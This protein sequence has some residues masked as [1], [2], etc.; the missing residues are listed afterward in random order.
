MDNL[1]FFEDKGFVVLRDFWPG[2]EL[3]AL[4]DQ[5]DELGRLVVGNNFSSI[6]RSR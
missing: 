4:Q 6:D 3:D 5:L 1:Q 2:G